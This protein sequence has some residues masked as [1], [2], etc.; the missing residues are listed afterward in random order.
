MVGFP[1]ID[2]FHPDSA[3]LELIDEACSDLG[4]RLFLRIRDEMGLAYFVGSSIMS[5]LAGGMFAFYLGTAPEKLTEVKAALAEEIEKL[6]REGL[7]P[8]EVAR[9]KEKSIGQQDIR[10]QSNSA[11][12]FQAALNEL[13]G[14]GHS[15]HLLQRE[16]I[17]AITTEE[18][19]R[20]AREYF[21]QPSV[22]VVVRPAERP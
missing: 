3:A 22:T 5:G 8:E 13:Y 15:Y 17:Q 19:R 6:A 2:L 11:F 7:S 12:A 4:S 20:V 18:L 9:A 1:G 21:H 16:Q 14:L 10:N